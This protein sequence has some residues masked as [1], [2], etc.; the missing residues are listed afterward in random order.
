M[1]ALGISLILIAVGAILTYA[2][3]ATVAGVSLTAIG[4]ILM[5]VGGLGILMALLFMMSFSPF[6][7]RD[8]VVSRDDH[9]HVR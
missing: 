4:V 9:L 6:A 2:V 5:V 1:P 3:S 8:E 7:S